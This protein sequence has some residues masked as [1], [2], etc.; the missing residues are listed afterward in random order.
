MPSAAE[1]DRGSGGSFDS[2]REVGVRFAGRESKHTTHTRRSPA[3]LEVF[4]EPSATCRYSG[5][6]VVIAMTKCA[7][8]PNNG[9]S[10]S[11][12]RRLPCANTEV[13]N[14]LRRTRP[15]RARCSGSPSTKQLCSEPILRWGTDLG[16][17]DI[18]HLHERWCERIVRVFATPPPGRASPG[19]RCRARRDVRL[20]ASSMRWTPS[21]KASSLF[22]CMK[23][24]PNV[25]ISPKLTYQSVAEI[26]NCLTA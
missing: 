14:A 5:T 6:S 1:F 18:T 26:H 12:A 23:A 2:G 13:I 20:R 16:S 9:T 8:L 22:R 17:S 3:G 24:P 15:S 7:G 10:I 25:K 19:D 21:L 11:A 4:G